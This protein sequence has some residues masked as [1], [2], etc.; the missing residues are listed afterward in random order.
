MPHTE[1]LIKSSR[2]GKLTKDSKRLY[3]KESGGQTIGQQAL[4]L[5]Y[6]IKVICSL[7]CRFVW[8]MAHCGHV[9]DTRWWRVQQSSCGYL[10]ARMNLDYWSL[11][12]VDGASEHIRVIF[13]STRLSRDSWII[14][15]NELRFLDLLIGCVECNVF[16]C[17]AALLTRTQVVNT[18]NSMRFLNPFDAKWFSDL[19]YR[20]PYL[21]RII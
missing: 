12:K 7:T 11:R 6:S 9:E 19:C 18:S 1:S 5:T 8:F 17:R 21:L 10:E 20:S 16:Y 14:T 4:G 15:P 3:S 13:L 2:S